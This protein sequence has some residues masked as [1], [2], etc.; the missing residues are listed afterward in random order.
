MSDLMGKMHSAQDAVST[1]AP[2]PRRSGCRSPFQR[3][4][5]SRATT[6]RR[7]W[8]SRS[9]SAPSANSRSGSF[10]GNIFGGA[11]NSNGGSGS[12][13]PVVD[14]SGSIVKLP[15]MPRSVRASANLNEKEMVEVE[16]I[17]AL[18]SSYFDIVRKNIGDMVP[19]TVM[20]FLVNHAKENVQSTLV[21]R[22]YRD[23]SLDDLLRETDDT[24][25]RRRNCIEVRGLLRRALEIVNEVRDFNAF[26]M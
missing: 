4:Q 14:A 2:R 6:E 25:Q 7:C 5:R 26:G 1:I 12:E 21:Q 13:T 17:K 23:S 15:Q 9:T 10:F 20:C 22:L 19:K 18:I 11:E 24:A 16:I 3:Q 8:G